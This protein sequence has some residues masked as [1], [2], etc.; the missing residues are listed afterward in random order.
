[1]ATTKTTAKK[2]ATPVEETNAPEIEAAPAVKAERVAETRKLDDTLRVVVQSNV[3][4][5][6]IFINRRTGDRTEW[7]HFGDKQTL[8]M[9]DLRS[10]RGSQRGF[11]ENN[12]IFVDRVDE[13][14]YEDITPEDIYKTLMVT[15]YYKDTLTPDNFNEFFNLSATEIKDRIYRMSAAAKTNLIVAANDGIRNGTLDSLRAI[16][17]IEEALSCELVKID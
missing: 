5:A 2:K 16:H 17:A 3:H 4:G 9:G 8:T 7:D 1:M 11:F 13:D 6:L 10:M 15:Q 12:W 14:G